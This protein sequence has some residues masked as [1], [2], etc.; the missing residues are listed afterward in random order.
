VLGLVSARRGDLAGALSAFRA[1]AAEGSL[2]PLVHFELGHAEEF[3]GNPAA[4][5]A[6]YS[7]AAALTGNRTASEGAGQ[8]ARR[9]RCR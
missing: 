9:L 4:A 2:D 3:A 6:A 5:C 8:A 7:R 1:A